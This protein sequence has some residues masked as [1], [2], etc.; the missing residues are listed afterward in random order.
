[1]RSVFV[2]ADSTRL[3]ERRTCSGLAGG[4]SPIEVVAA[5]S[6][7]ARLFDPCPI[8]AAGVRRRPGALP[9]GPDPLRDRAPSTRELVRAEAIRRGVTYQEWA[10]RFVASAPAPARAVDLVAA[11]RMID[12]RTP[13]RQPSVNVTS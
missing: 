11:E 5:G 8:C 3:H 6:R 10:T 4:R 1:M 7:R 2:A 13:A 9:A 12:L